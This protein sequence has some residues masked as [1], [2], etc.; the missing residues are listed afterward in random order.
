M[1]AAQIVVITAL[2]YARPGMPSLLF[3]PCVVVHLVKTFRVLQRHETRPA[4]RSHSSSLLPPLRPPCVTLRSLLLRASFADATFACD[5]PQSTRRTSLCWPCCSSPRPARRPHRRAWRRG[6]ISSNASRRS[7]TYQT[8]Y[9]MLFRGE[10][11]EL[12]RRTACRCS[13]TDPTICLP[14]CLLKHLTT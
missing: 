5:Q 3:S 14:I 10:K 13:I 12:S 8:R 11:R 4:R 6:E 1:S 9:L 7:F 2:V